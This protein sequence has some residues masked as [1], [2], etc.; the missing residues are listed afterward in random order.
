[1]SLGF[2]KNFLIPKERQKNVQPNE[3]KAQPNKK[4]VESAETDIY[5]AVKFLLKIKTNKYF[6]QFRLRQFR[7]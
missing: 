2:A 7:D 5:A 6:L 3:H 1:M 4:T